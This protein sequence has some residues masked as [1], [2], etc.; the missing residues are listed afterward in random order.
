MVAKKN[1]RPRKQALK[2]RFK[3]DPIGTTKAE[4]K[5]TG[6]LQIPLAA[7]ALGAIG[8]TGMAVALSRIPMIGGILQVMA[9]KGAKLT[10][11]FSG[12]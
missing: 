8:G 5:K 7:Y 12:K 3:K 1:S 9:N 6:P 11:K 10:S 2:T 4:V